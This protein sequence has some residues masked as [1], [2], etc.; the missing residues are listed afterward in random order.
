MKTAESGAWG[1]VKTAGKG[2]LSVESLKWEF[3]NANRR[4]EIRESGES[5]E[6]GLL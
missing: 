1:H 6:R 5:G 2:G 4:R 3:Y